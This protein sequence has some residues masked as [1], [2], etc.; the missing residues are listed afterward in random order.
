[1]PFKANLF[2]II[3]ALPLFGKQLWFAASYGGF[4]GAKRKHKDYL[5]EGNV[6]ITYFAHSF[7]IIEIGDKF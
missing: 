6:F 1:M 2:F 3:Q 7:S 5:V 4:E